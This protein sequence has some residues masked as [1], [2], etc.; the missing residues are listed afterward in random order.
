MP[1]NTK[2]V[3]RK[4]SEFDVMTPAQRRVVIAKDVIAAID[5]GKLSSVRGTFVDVDFEIPERSI[6]SQL[7]AK[8]KGVHCNVCA[9]GGV[10]IS[11]EIQ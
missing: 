4:N 2:T 5:K 6:N 7:N 8:V 11:A 9:I 1:K 3:K 10:F